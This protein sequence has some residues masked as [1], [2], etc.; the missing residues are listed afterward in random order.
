MLFTG[1]AAKPDLWTNRM[2]E[3]SARMTEGYANECTEL[4]MDLST[5]QDTSV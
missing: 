3:G 5:G 2:T 4:L 1:K